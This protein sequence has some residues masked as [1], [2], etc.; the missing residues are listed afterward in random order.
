M[1]NQEAINELQLAIDLIK[2][3]GKDW[4]DERDIPILD[5]AISAL[6]KQDKQR[7]IPVSERLPE[8]DTEVLVYLF[9]RPSPYIAWVSDCHWY[10]EEFEIEKE[11]YPIA[12]MPLPEPYKG[13]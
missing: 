1:T 10:T 2:Q 11:N 12:W 5:M 9:S 13:E 7:W 3:D 4:L 6:E 8:D